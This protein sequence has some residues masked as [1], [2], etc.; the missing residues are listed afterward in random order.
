MDLL[1]DLEHLCL[2][3]CST[4]SQNDFIQIRVLLFLR[5]SKSLSFSG[6]SFLGSDTVQYFL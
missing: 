2:R 3:M 6:G 5:S 1:L 4:I